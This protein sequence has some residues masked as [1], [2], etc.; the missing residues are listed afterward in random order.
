MHVLERVEHFDAISKSRLVTRSCVSSWLFDGE[1]REFRGFAKV[2]Q[3]DTESFDADGGIGRGTHTPDEEL[4]LP[5]VRTVSWFH[6]GAF[7]E[8]STLSSGFS[9]STTQ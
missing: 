6:N 4:V 3:W 9:R 5:P 2:E 7:F 8:A 1:E